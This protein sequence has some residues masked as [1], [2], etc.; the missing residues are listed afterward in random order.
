MSYDPTEIKDTPCRCCWRFVPEDELL[1]D[2][3]I[4]CFED[5][6]ALKQEYEDNKD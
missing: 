6:E 2:M 5:N 1:D 3:C 4:D